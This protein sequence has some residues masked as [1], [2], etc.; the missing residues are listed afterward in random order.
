MSVGVAPLAITIVNLPD[1]Q[2]GSYYTAW[3]TANAGGVLPLT[4]SLIG[5]TLPKGLSMNAQGVIFGTPEVA[6]LTN[7]LTVMVQDSS[8]PPPP[9]SASA[10]V[11][12]NIGAAPAPDPANPFAQFHN[13]SF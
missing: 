11:S 9:Q 3:L 12:L 1:G 13:A 4:W 7:Q 6:S 2:V 10:I 5:G 8:S